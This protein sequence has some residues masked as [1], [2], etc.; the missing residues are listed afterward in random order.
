MNSFNK[1]LVVVFVCLLSF[2]FSGVASAAAKDNQAPQT[3]TKNTS[4]QISFFFTVDAKTATFKPVNNKT[5]QA[6]FH[7]VKNVTFVSYHPQLIAGE[8][9]VERFAKEVWTGNSKVNIAISGANSPTRGKCTH[10][11]EAFNPKYDA[12]TKDF[13]VDVIGFGNKA[14]PV[15]KAPKETESYNVT[16]LV[17]GFPIEAQKAKT[18]LTYDK[19]VFHS[20]Y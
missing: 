4:G 16:L 5:D 9:E 6:I 11:F 10:L 3:I 20:E 14:L 2:I 19:C 12:A 13:T 15:F 7:N 18:F 1:Y 17:S 8:M